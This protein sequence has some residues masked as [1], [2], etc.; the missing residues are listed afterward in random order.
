MERVRFGEVGVL[1]GTVGEMLTPE[2]FVTLGVSLGKREKVALGWSGGDGAAMLARAL[3]AGI[4]AGG[5]T[6]LAHDG[7]CSAA[8]AWM[9]AYYGVD[10]SLFVEQEGERAY[11]HW[12][13]G[14]GLAPEWEQVRALEQHWRTGC[15]ERVKGGLVGAWEPLVGVNTAYAADA[16]RRGG[17]GE[18]HVDAVVSVPGES[19]WEQTLANALERMG[20]RVL[21]HAERGVPSFAAAHGGFWLEGRTEDGVQVDCVRMLALLARLELE[22]GACVAVPVWAPA[23]IEEMAAQLGRNVLR[24]GRDKGA[25]EV[26]AAAPQLRDALFAAAHVAAAL[27]REGKRLGEL[28]ERVPPFALSRAEIP[29]RRGGEKVMDAFTGRFRRAEPAGPGVRLQAGG[30]WVTVTPMRRRQAVQV[31]AEGESAEMAQEL[32]GFYEDEIR[33]LDTDA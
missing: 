21:R 8:G 23:V 25:R 30:G 12:F 16:A 9:G 5:G 27:G 1:Q 10:T 26:Y 28:L 11:L 20:C 33:R 13:C 4:C 24:L 7:C 2:E 31:Q 18:F 14:D 32:C 17:R 3:G 19:L 29:L 15:G 22:R 6:V